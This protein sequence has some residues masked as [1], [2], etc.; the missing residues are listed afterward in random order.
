MVMLSKSVVSLAFA[1]SLMAAPAF[2]QSTDLSPT[3]P[4]P[5]D[6]TTMPGP[7]TDLVTNGPQS[8]Q[9]DHARNWSATRNVRESQRYDH[10]VATNPGFRHF[11]ER[12]ECGPIT[13][14]QMHSQCMAS[15]ESGAESYGSSSPPHPIRNSS[16]ASE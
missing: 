3:A 2:A 9:G 16:G 11:R 1:A 15:F 5:T 14:A 8:N 13:D 10:L 6:Q 4:V 7:Q 12:K